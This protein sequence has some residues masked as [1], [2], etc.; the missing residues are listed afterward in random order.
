MHV[1]P[2]AVNSIDTS[3]RC[4]H[5]TCDHNFLKQMM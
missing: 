3:L 2:F 5:F 1:K 4:F